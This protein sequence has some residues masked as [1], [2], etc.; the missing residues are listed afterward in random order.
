[1]AGLKRGSE[2]HGQDTQGEDQGAG[3]SSLVPRG[4]GSAPEAGAPQ[5]AVSGQKNAGQGPQWLGPQE[6]PQFHKASRSL[7][8]Q[9]QRK[10]TGHPS[11]PCHTVKEALFHSVFSPS[12]GRPHPFHS[13][14]PPS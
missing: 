5:G 2:G 8:K 13:D 9:Q 3:H 10:E 4:K 14:I 7:Q 1:M 12:Q 11:S 6:R